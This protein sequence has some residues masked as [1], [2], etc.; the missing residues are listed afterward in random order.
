MLLMQRGVYKADMASA[1][2]CKRCW[3]SSGQTDV[4]RL[5]AAWTK[6]DRPT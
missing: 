4:A 6:P 3:M 2:G 5:P 1:V